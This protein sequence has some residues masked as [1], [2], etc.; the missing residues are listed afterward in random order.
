MASTST[1]ADDSNILPA[2]Q[3]SAMLPPVRNRQLLTAISTWLFI[4]I[5][6][7]VCFKFNYRF[8]LQVC[9]PSFPLS[10]RMALLS[11]SLPIPDLRV[12]S[13]FLLFSS[14]MFRQEPCLADLT[15]VVWESVPPLDSPQHLG[16][17]TQQSL[18]AV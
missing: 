13:D 4:S 14:C 5:S 6:D 12:I 7:L 17:G 16:S 15:S 10:Q 8:Y 3:I 18:S 2:P 1:Y 9:P 11:A